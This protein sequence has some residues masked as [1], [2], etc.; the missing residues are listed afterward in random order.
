MELVSE[1][2]DRVKAETDPRSADFRYSQIRMEALFAQPKRHSLGNYGDN[3]SDDSDSLAPLKKPLN[4]TSARRARAMLEFV[5]TND[6]A[7][8]WLMVLWQPVYPLFRLRNLSRP[9]LPVRWLLSVT[10]VLLLIADMGVAFWIM[11]EYYC[12]QI[13]DPTAQDSG[14]SR[15]ALWSVLGVLPAAIVGSPLLG[16]IFVTRKSIFSGKL[17]VVWNVSS[18]VNQVVAFIC[19]LAFLAYIHDEILLVAVGGVLIKY[20]EKEVALRCIA[21]YASER[22]LRGWRGLHT[23]RDWYD[24]AYTPLVHYES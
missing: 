21:Q 2:N 10:M 15:T 11:V 16:L 13:R 17:F 14:C 6:T 12:V 18:I 3:S 22:P 19:G 5:C 7:K 23:T 20:L 1:T 8:R 9:E 24:A 4:G